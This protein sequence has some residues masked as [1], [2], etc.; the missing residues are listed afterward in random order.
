[1]NYIG[2]YRGYR[3]H[4]AYQDFCSRIYSIHLIFTLCAQFQ[5][6]LLWGNWRALSQWTLSWNF[7]MHNLL[8]LTREPVL[9][10]PEQWLVIEPRFPPFHLPFSRNRDPDTTR[11]PSHVLYQT[12]IRNFV[13]FSFSSVCNCSQHFEKLTRTESRS[14]E[15]MTV[16]PQVIIIETGNDCIMLIFKL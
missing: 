13:L 2:R 15:I 11:R 12:E 1:M 9:L 7:C 4:E 8:Q 14:T 5:V 10:I 6:S 16:G 3:S